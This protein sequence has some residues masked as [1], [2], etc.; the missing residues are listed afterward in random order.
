MASTM[1]LEVVTPERKLVD[2]AVSFV[3]LRGLA[4]ELGITPNHAPLATGVAP[5]VL[6]YVQD[7]HDHVVAVMD[8]FV[9]VLPDRVQVLVE[10]AEL[11]AEINAERARLAKDKAEADMA[12][13]EGRALMAEAALARA[14]ARLKAVELV[15]GGRR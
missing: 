3:A 6:K 15:G 1:Q 7:G 14:L 5:G 2:Q 10:A 9:S 11:G 4:G 8:G 12:K 13:E